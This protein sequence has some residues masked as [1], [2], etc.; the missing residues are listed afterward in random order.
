MIEQGDG[1]L[2]FNHIPF[3]GNPFIFLLTTFIII[4]PFFFL[5]VL[6]RKWGNDA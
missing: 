4:L 2:F 5:L 1:L 3:D 6:S